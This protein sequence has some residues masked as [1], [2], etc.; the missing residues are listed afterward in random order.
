MVTLVSITVDYRS[1]PI[2]TYLTDPKGN[3]KV[4]CTTEEIW[5]VICE[6]LFTVTSLENVHIK[7]ECIE[8]KIESLVLSD[9][10]EV[11]IE[12]H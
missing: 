9:L 4:F 10:W 3:E 8:G 2:V 6:C 1:V 5:L 7:F 12:G 11:N